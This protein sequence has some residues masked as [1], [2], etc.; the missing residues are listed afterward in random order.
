M[1]VLTLYE[2]ES[3]S[4]D[5]ASAVWPFHFSKLSHK[6]LWQVVDCFTT[7]LSG[8]FMKQQKIPEILIC[9]H[10]YIVYKQKCNSSMFDIIW[11]LIFLS[12]RRCIC[13]GSIGRA[14]SF[15]RI[16]FKPIGFFSISDYYQFSN[17]FLN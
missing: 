6:S 7:L 11:K 14:Y 17:D 8:K 9:N 4:S 12:E 5:Q 1:A 10:N 15:I 16:F 2:R 3:L 13:V